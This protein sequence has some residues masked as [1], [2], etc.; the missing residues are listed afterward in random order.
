M[1]ATNRQS[2][3]EAL[4]GRSMFVPMSPDLVAAHVFVTIAFSSYREFASSGFCTY[5]RHC[6]IVRIVY[7]IIREPKARRTFIVGSHPTMNALCAFCAIL[8]EGVSLV[9]GTAYLRKWTS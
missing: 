1:F 9:V 8:G 6:S 4:L 2:T 7:P 3:A 5:T